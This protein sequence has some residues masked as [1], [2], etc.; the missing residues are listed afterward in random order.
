MKTLIS[1]LFTLAVSVS[2]HAATFI[3]TNVNDSGA[4]SLR[5]AITDANTASGDDT[6]NFLSGFDTITLTG[7]E[8]LINSNITISATELSPITVTRSAANGTPN[9]R[10]LNV[11]AG[12]NVSINNLIIS[13][14][15]L[16]TG[17]GGIYNQG[18]LTLT[19][20]TIKDNNVEAAAA[21]GALS[22]GGGIYNEGAL[23]LI[24]SAV[25]N[26]RAGCMSNCD[27]VSGYGGGIANTGTLTLTDTNINGNKVF[28]ALGF[29]IAGSA[30][31]GGVY[32]TNTFNSVNSLI[33]NNSSIATFTRG[34]GVYSTGTTNLT[35]SPIVG[36]GAS[37]GGNSN[38]SAY[39]GGVYSSGNLMIQNNTVENN[40]VGALDA[41]GG[42]IYSGGSLI[43]TNSMFA[44][45]RI[46]SSSISWGG[47]ICIISGTANISGSTVMQNTFGDGDPY[48]NG[49]AALGG[50]TTITDST[51]K[52]HIGHNGSGIYVGNATMN[53]TNS[54][55]S[56]NLGIYGGGIN[57][58]NGTINITNSKIYGNSALARG[59]GVYCILSGTTV[60]ITNSTVNNN[61][62][63]TTYDG[64]GGGIF[65]YGALN[66][67]NSTIS[68]NKSTV[69]GGGVASN[70]TTELKNSTIAY[71]SAS[72]TIPPLQTTGGGISGNATL[73]NTIV[74]N[75]SAVSGP[76][77]NGSA[78]SNGNNLIGNTSGSSG[79]ITS[80]IL[81]VNAN[82]APLGDYGGPTQT[83][84][85]ISNSPAIN[86]GN[87]QNAPATDQR[88]LARIVGGTIDIGAYEFQNA[89]TYS[90]SPTSVTISAAGGTATVTVTTS[91]DC[92][93]TTSSSSPNATVS[94][95]SGSGN[96]TVTITAPA[97][98]GGARSTPVII[99]GK[100]VA[101]NQLS[102]CVYSFNPTS[103]NFIPEG[104]NANV[105][106]V[107]GSTCSWIAVSNASWISVTGGA[108]G[109]GNGFVQ[110]LV[111]PNPSGQSR[112]GTITIAGEIFTVNQAGTCTFTF[113]QTAVTFPASG[114]SGTILISTNDPQCS[115]NAVSNDS[116]ILI[117]SVSPGTGSVTYSVEQN[118]GAQRVGTIN[119]AGQVLTITQL[120]SAANRRALFDFDGDGKADISVFRPSTGAWYLLNSQDGFV[121]TQFGQ[122]GDLIVPAD[123]DG[124]GKADLAVYRNGTWYIQRSQ[125]GFTGIQF[126]AATDIP[127]PADFDGDGKADLA[128]FRP[129]NGTWYLQRTTLG[130][131]GIQFGQ[132]GDTPVAADFDG[133]GRADIAVFRPSNGGWYIQQS[134][135]GFRAQQFGISEDKPVAADYDGDG[136]ADIAV[137]RPSNGTWFLQQ[138]QNGFT[139]IQFGVSGDLPVAADYDGDGKAD[140]AVYR[141]NIWYLLRS[142]QGFT[143]VQFG[144]TGDL[145]VP[146]VF[147]R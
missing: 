107:A 20:T 51:I 119:I 50:A 56:D 83:V 87:N 33:S 93:W 64:I 105:M 84:A 34:G 67:T 25:N 124:D 12:A 142:S 133:D 104:G 21:L 10:I 125:L 5:Q 95:S 38:S 37:T 48:G 130:F 65:S 98:N 89:C 103:V 143:G 3:V 23:F 91:V 14:G 108:S 15:F 44:K 80:D 120:A 112:N 97:N 113:S 92:A 11:A 106:V 4:G 6:I 99:A 2:I 42:G 75:N 144:T 45:N 24:N 18:T 77:V 74:S 86:A 138:S 39:G 43:V 139:G 58:Q 7:G 1:L 137:F 29:T 73:I 135:N 68:N 47:G 57:V 134:T 94:P 110:Y 131:T 36:N 146:N 140:I 55:I 41:K 30:F 13:N 62:V 63:G 100:V 136:K 88:G 31:G 109:A 59:G 121:G 9:F 72:S 32:N 46:G 61:T 69:D 22:V 116:W 123:Y 8:L 53:I 35:N 127:V 78:V 81:N 49:I 40:G 115:F 60:N 52:N 27:R 126:G 70:G 26:N 85:L 54:T 102:G 147:V 141:N 16:T 122:N 145:P 118:T 132:S 28:G 79:W 71:N 17:G 114:G 90:V 117:V 128:T 111:A 76:D 96:G 19:N 66:I 129:S 101:V 82:L